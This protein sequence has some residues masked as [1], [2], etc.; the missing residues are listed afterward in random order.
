MTAATPARPPSGQSIG[1]IHAT[2]EP[3]AHGSRDGERKGT[4]MRGSWPWQR[5]ETCSAATAQRPGHGK[6]DK[7]RWGSVGRGG[8][9][10]PGTQQPAG[11]ADQGSSPSR[12]N[13]ATR[14]GTGPAPGFRCSV[15]DAAAAHLFCCARARGV[16]IPRQTRRAVRQYSG[17]VTPSRNGVACGPDDPHRWPNS[18]GP[19][20]CVLQRGARPD[21]VPVPVWNE[22]SFAFQHFRR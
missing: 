18:R 9:A 17:V 15:D 21:A 8:L 4:R 5:N 10:D 12:S 11:V 6:A 3:C 7:W 20:S 14:C 2:C 1:A 22:R 13:G 16:V 19:V